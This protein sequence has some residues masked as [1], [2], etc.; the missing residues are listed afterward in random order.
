MKEGQEILCKFYQEVLSIT[1][2]W[3]A[4]DV[5]KDDGKKDVY[6]RVEYAKERYACPECGKEAKLHDHR[7][8]RLRHLDTC[9]YQTILEVHV[10]RVACPEHKTKQLDVRF[11]EK[12]SM[13]TELFEMRVIEWLKTMS[14]KAVAEKV[15]L[16]WDAIDNIQGRAV[17][18]GLSRRKEIRVE[19]MGIDETSYRKGHDYVTTI[20]D[21]GSGNIL[22]V[23]DG[24]DS[25]VVKRWFSEEK[26]VDFRGIKSVSMDMSRAYIKAVKDRF[27][28][29][30][31]I[32]CFD[33]F[34]IAQLLNKAVDRVRREEYVEL[35]KSGKENVLKKRRFE[36]LINSGRVDNRSGKRR[37]FLSITRLRIKTAK[38]WQIKE[39]ASLLW[40]YSYIGVAKKRW[41]SLLWWMSH[42]RIEAMI[43]AGKTIK[44]H[45]WGILNAIRMKMNNAIAESKNSIIQRIKKMACGFRNKERFKTAIL[46]HLGGLDMAI[47]SP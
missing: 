46:F 27:E 6:I 29:W 25:A 35:K 32:I 44:E 28:R 1:P 40:E 5:W 16:S 8:R 36:F 19:H 11:A 45:L 22:A 12:H 4:T 14:I 43:Q 13:Y 20:I 2:E 3:K 18:R 23:L 33:R 15:K 9:D 37:E 10:P 41:E 38:A 21:K 17:K 31:E 47:S 30:E 26:L 34:H 42:C 7:I 39:T 24:R